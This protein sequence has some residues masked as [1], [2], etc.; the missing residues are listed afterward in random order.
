MGIG[1][2]YKYG[3]YSGDKNWIRDSYINEADINY[4]HLITINPST[5]GSVKAVPYEEK[6]KTVNLNIAPDPGYEWTGTKVTDKAGNVIAQDQ[7]SFKMPDKDVIVTS[8]FEKATRDVTIYFDPGK[9]GS[10]TMK[11]KTVPQGNYELPSC[12]FAPPQGKEFKAW[13]VAGAEHQPGETINVI[14]NTTLTAIWTEKTVVPTTV[15][16]TFDGNGGQWHMD[17][18]TVARGSVYELPGCS[19]VAPD[20][21]KEFDAWSI[22]GVRHN[23]GDRITVNDNIT[24]TALWKDKAAPQP[25]EYTITSFTDVGGS[26][27]ANKPKAIENGQVTLTINTN[28]GYTLER[29]WLEDSSGNFITEVDTT[30]KSF[31]M[32]AKDVAIKA[33]FKVKDQTQYDISVEQTS[34]GNVEVNKT[35]ASEGEEVIVK[36][37]PQ[38]GYEVGQVKANSQVLRLQ[39]GEYKFK[40][41]PN[42][43]KI[44]A[45]FNKIEYKTY[46]VGISGDDTKGW[47]NVDDP[48]NKFARAGQE[49]RFTVKP[50]PGFMVDKVKI[51][52]TDASGELNTL[53]FNGKTGTFIMPDVAVTINVTYKEYKVPEG[54]YLVTLGTGISGGTFEFDPSEAK[55]GEKI[56][57]T[58]L[59]KPGYK[60]NSYKVTTAQGGANVPIETDEL[61]LYFTMPKADVS[62]NGIF[63]WVGANA[64][65]Y[66][67]KLS[68]PEHGTL[69]ANFSKANAGDEIYINAKP[70]NG[71]A[72][73]SLTVN[74]DNGTKVEL[75]GNKFTMPSSGVSV[76]ASFKEVGEEIPQ[77]GFAGI[78]IS[79]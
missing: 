49:V 33:T 35:K 17:P 45:T 78:P 2:D 28:A 24:V 79:K 34:G 11:S 32:P 44:S 74:A 25:T 63:D 10:G 39:N 72:L 16:I 68:P 46:F 67:V 40:M 3:S 26:V 53:V 12:T 71:Y 75:K 15:T 50:K 19:F 73:D 60:V 4:K 14:A 55:A 48:Q 42:N 65:T 21:T 1:L 70:E 64:G 29:I 13:S 57:L 31:T 52:K 30:S 36:V 22:N 69:S 20:N 8:T 59:P 56:R 38:Q 5:G 6:D 76:T 23:P 54:S 18:K 7:W 62:V 37:T 41:P 77:D 51:T 27:T 61:G 9:G 47:I 66:D 58:V 43:V